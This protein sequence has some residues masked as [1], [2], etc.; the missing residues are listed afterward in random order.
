MACLR[1]RSHYIVVPH[2]PSL[3]T[4]SLPSLF[5]SRWSSDQL[6]IMI[7]EFVNDTSVL[8]VSQFA[9]RDRWCC[10]H[11][12]PYYLLL[13]IL[14]L[15]L[16]TT[17]KREYQI[18]HAQFKNT[19]SDTTLIKYATGCCQLTSHF[20]ITYTNECRKRHQG[21]CSIIYTWWWTNQSS[22]RLSVH[23]DNTFSCKV[24][25]TSSHLQQRFYFLCILTAYGLCFL[26]Y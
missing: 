10:W 7:V 9:Y 11:H 17:F 2:R 15:V 16:N 25:Y 13:L 14:A 23:L 22:L 18:Q 8:D 19:L 1:R 3:G 4:L 6:K 12:L 26:F 21:S 24:V 5:Q 20:H